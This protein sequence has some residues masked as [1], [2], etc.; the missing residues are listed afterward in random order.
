ML[1]S[2]VLD[3]RYKHSGMTGKGLPYF[4]IPPLIGMARAGRHKAYPYIGVAVG[5]SNP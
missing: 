4:Y 5:T 3:S 1:V 2:R